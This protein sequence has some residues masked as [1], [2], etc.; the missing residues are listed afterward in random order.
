LKVQQA[1]R[2]RIY[3]LREAVPVLPSRYLLGNL[4]SVRTS[5]ISAGGKIRLNKN[6]LTK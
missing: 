1:A 4:T 2:V 3:A 5:H 6:P